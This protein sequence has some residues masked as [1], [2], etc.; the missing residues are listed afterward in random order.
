MPQRPYA[1]IPAVPLIQ[2]GRC[3]PNTQC[4]SLNGGGDEGLPKTVTAF[5]YVVASPYGTRILQYFKYGNENA[6]VNEVRLHTI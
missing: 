4:A 6:A 5:G 2:H 3:Q 1:F